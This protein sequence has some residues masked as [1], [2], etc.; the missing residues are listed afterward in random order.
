M[1]SLPV[2]ISYSDGE[3]EGAGVGIAAWFADGT[4]LGGYHA[5]PDEVRALWA[6][7][8]SADGLVHDIFEIEAVGPALV[9]ANWG[10]R[11]RGGLWL[12]FIDNEG[13]LA[14][15]VKG[16]SSVLSGEC[17]AAYTHVKIAELGLWPWFDRVDSKSN[18]VDGLSR[19]RFQGEWKL[20]DIVFPIELISSISAFCS[21]RSCRRHAS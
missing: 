9:L 11:M 20:V 10:E 3:G 2:T 4:I 8:P 13:A 21:S 14:T 15:L 12:H 16:S 17:I 6:R 1:T 5:I 7:P 19:G 18:P